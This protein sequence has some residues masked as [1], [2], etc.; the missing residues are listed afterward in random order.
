MFKCPP[1]L[2]MPASAA[3]IGRAALMIVVPE[4]M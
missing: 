2:T 4:S 1:P 3:G